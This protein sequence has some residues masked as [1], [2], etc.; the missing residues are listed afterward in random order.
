MS[1]PWSQLICC[2]VLLLA[3]V[4]WADTPELVLLEAEKV[5]RVGDITIAEG[6]VT[7]EVGGVRL[8]CQRL[9]YNTTTQYLRAERECIFYWGNNYAT[10]DELTYDALNNRAEMTDA[11]GKGTDLVHHNRLVESPLFF[12]AEKLVWTPEKVELEEAVVT[13]CDTN[14]EELHYY[15]ESEKI[16]VYPQDK[17]VATN[18][19]INM[20]GNKLYTVPTLVVPLEDQS[21]KQQTYF[22]SVGYNKLDGAFLRNRF[23]YYFD[24]RNYGTLN[25]DLYQRSGLGGGVDHFFSLGE[26]G[27]GN[28]FYYTQNGRQSARNRSELRANAYYSLDE[29]S[30]IGVAYNSNQFELP[31]EVSTQNEAAAINF[32]RYTE[33][34]ALVLGANFARSGD[35]RNSSYRFFYNVNLDDRWSGLLAADLSRSGTLVTE[36]SRFHYLG[37]LRHRGDLFDGELAYER[38]GGQNTFFLNREPELRLKTKQLYVGPV[39]VQ[40]AGAFGSLEEGPS[41]F[42]TERYRLDFQVPDQEIETGLGNFHAGAG[43]RQTLYGSGQEQYVLGARAGW[44]ETFGDHALARLDYNW[45]KPEGFTPFQH[46]VA[47]SYETLTGGLE[48]YNDEYWSVSALAGY[49]LRYEVAQDVITRLDLRPWEGWQV[50]ATANLDPNTGTWR[51]VDSGVTMQLTPGVSVTHW[52]VYDLLNGRLTYQNFAL[53]YEDHDWI[54]SLAYRGVQN[55]VFLQMSLKAF[56][57]RPL[58]IGPDPGQP[59]LPANLSN[60][61]V[62]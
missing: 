13:S 1:R 50:T 44:T 36:T 51:R 5:R 32:S 17:M 40:V 23:D 47:Y 54:A 53:N 41:F 59:V 7:A 11:V 42:R 49:D 29:F 9:E 55:E 15:V 16:E 62:R 4:G 26:R 24:K 10:S 2:L 38:S 39:P 8:D 58:K 30:N 52:S 25:F 45:Q 46:D 21:E 56:P 31:G 20:H 37:S 28:L 6:N 34:S 57:I 3:A 43:F 33:E 35:N 12:W 60:A 18:S 27:G 61:F 19:S 48:L 14:A 22:P